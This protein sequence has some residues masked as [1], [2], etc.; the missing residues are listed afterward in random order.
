VHHRQLHAAGKAIPAGT[1]SAASVARVALVAVH[2]AGRSEVEINNEPSFCMELHPLFISCGKASTVYAL[3]LQT[4]VLSIQKTASLYN[5]RYCFVDLLYS[6]RNRN[7]T[8]T[9]R[10]YF[11]LYS[12]FCSILCMFLPYNER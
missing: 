10:L 1:V 12:I 6:I 2:L 5:I 7:A 3:K 4:T 9:Y 8:K 11:L